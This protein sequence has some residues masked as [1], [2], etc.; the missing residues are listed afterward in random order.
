M[1][2]R[3]IFVDVTSRGKAKRH[4]AGPGVWFLESVPEK[5]CDKDS[6][7]ACGGR[8]AERGPH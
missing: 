3:G 2:P 1:Q 4:R 8:S 6:D 7:H 5:E